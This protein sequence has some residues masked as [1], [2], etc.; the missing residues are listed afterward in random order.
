MEKPVSSSNKSVAPS[1]LVFFDARPLLGEPAPDFVL[2]SFGG[3]ALRLLPGK[4]ELMKDS[5]HMIAMV[6]DTELSSDEGGDPGGGPKVGLPAM[7]SWALEQHLLKPPFLLRVK[8]LGTTGRV[9]GFERSLPLFLKCFQPFGHGVA[10]H[11][12]L[13]CNIRLGLSLLQLI[14]RGLSSLR[15]LFA[16][17]ASN[18]I[19]SIHVFELYYRE[20]LLSTY[21]CSYQ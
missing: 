7:R 10:R 13:P 15:P 2:V 3:L 19:E 5:S 9:S 17:E 6:A 21:Y 8:T 18:S 20:G 11:P 1:S 14:Y 12:K 16:R 4:T